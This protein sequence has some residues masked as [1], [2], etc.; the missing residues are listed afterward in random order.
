MSWISRVL[1]LIAAILVR[2]L[3]PT[4]PP[5]PPSPKMARPRHQLAVFLAVLLPGPSSAADPLEPALPLVKLGWADV[6]PILAELGAYE[7]EKLAAEMEE[8]ADEMTERAGRDVEGAPPDCTAFDIGF[9]SALTLSTGLVLILF[10]PWATNIE[11]GDGQCVDFAED[12][13]SAVCAV[14]K[15]AI[16]VSNWVVVHVVYG[17]HT[18]DGDAPER[19]CCE[20]HALHCPCSLPPHTLCTK[21]STHV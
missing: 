2:F 16:T 6:E 9:A 12:L 8:L 3:S 21:P 19:K 10:N 14:I 17:K 18:R 7:M 11:W 1:L 15:R 20:G 4:R 5:P 13:V